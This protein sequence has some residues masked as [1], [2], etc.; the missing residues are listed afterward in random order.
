MPPREIPDLLWQHI[1]RRLPRFGV[2]DNGTMI[3]DYAFDRNIGLILKV[4]IFFP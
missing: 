4:Q 3:A 2:E 1:G